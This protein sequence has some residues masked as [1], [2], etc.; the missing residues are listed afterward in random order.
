M[1]EDTALFLMTCQLLFTS[2]RM[3][4][5]IAPENRCNKG[6]ARVKWK[7]EDIPSKAVGLP[8][9]SRNS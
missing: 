1:Q 2:L 9:D 6:P 4:E 7:I 5:L 8:R 3:L